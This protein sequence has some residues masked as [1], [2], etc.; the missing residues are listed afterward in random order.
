MKEPR[1]TALDFEPALHCGDLRLDEVI[2]CA[3]ARLESWL[4]PVVYTS[5]DIHNKHPLDKDQ[6]WNK[7][8]NGNAKFTARLFGVQEI[9]KK[10]CGHTKLVSGTIPDT[11]R[12]IELGATMKCADCGAELHA[13]W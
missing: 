12:W 7:H 10:E 8:N 5:E 4:G 11:D 6:F 9:E 13:Q 1:F 2:D 3:N